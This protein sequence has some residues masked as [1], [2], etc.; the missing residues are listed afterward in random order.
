MTVWSLSSPNTI[1]LKVYLAILKIA[2]IG[3]KPWL[4]E[5]N[6]AIELANAYPAIV[7]GVIVGN[8]CLDDFAAGAVTVQQLRADLQHVRSRIPNRN[9]FV[10]TCFGFYSALNPQK[11]P[12]VN[13]IPGTPPVRIMARN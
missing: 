4:K 3:R 8:E 12:M 11:L 6:T 13:L 2:N 5:M 1:P 7:Q 10:T 9:L